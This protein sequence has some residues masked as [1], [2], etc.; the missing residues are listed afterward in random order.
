M[1]AQKDNERMKRAWLKLF[2]GT[3]KEFL[4]ND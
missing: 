2:N 1:H 3:N 4:K